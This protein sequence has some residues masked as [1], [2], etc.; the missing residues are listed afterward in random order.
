[1]YRSVVQAPSLITTWADYLKKSGHEVKTV[2]YENSEVKKKLSST[3][4][5]EAKREQSDFVGVVLSDHEAKNLKEFVN[6]LS[7][8]KEELANRNAELHVLV[9]DTKFDQV[10]ELKAIARDVLVHIDAVWEIKMAGLASSN[11]DSKS[12]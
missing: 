1:M 8:L 6:M 10:N 4:Y 3:F 11:K 12:S 2:E 9:P 7:K 5:L